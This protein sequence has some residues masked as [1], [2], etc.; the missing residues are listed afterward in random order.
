MSKLIC[1]LTFLLL[2]VI[3]FGQTRNNDPVVIKGSDLKSFI[4]VSPSRIVGYKFNGT[5]LVQIPIQIDEIVVKEASA[6]YNNYG[7]AFGTISNNIV[8]DNISFYTDTN[9][10]TGADT[11]AL[12]DADDELVFMA[13]DAGSKLNICLTRPPGCVSDTT[14]EI[15]LR[16]PL[17]N[18]IVGY[19]YLF[20]QNGTLN[21]G[22]G[23]NYVNYNFTFANNYKQAYDICTGGVTENSTVTTA[24]YSMRFTKRW[25]EDE[26]KIAAGGASNVDILDRHQAFVYPNNCF[27]SEQTFSDS[28]GTVVTSKNGPVRAIRSVMGANSGVGTQITYKFT[29]SRVDYQVDFRVHPIGGFYDVY[30]LN[31]NAIGMMYY[32]NQNLKGVLING[33]QDSMMATNPN[34]W[35]LYTGNQGSIAVSYAYQTDIPLGSNSFVEAYYDDGGT[36]NPKHSCTGDG[37]AYGSSGFHLAT[38]L[39]TDYWA[40]TSGCGALASNFRLYRRH[41]ILPPSATT[42]QASIYANFA[43]NPITTANIVALLSTFCSSAN[44][45][46]MTSSN[47]VAGGTTTGG[48]TYVTGVNVTVTATANSGYSFVSW[49]ENGNQVSTTDSYTFNSSANRNL[50]ANFA[51]NSTSSFNVT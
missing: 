11:N 23:V 16:D 30:D 18:A 22:A 43:N 38:G 20:R 15:A 31:T 48:G 42:T 45:N 27:R 13:K 40:T 32:N 5:S 19:I 8:Y 10:F 3:T 1:A 47:P 17:N 41:Y 49:T 36:A 34:N 7:C 6:P 51:Q 50:V 44:Y 33:V 26:L 24:N 9:T 21:Q 35:E 25:I 2:Q 4:G 37:F 46:V 29:E 28:R 39:C 12:F 14:C